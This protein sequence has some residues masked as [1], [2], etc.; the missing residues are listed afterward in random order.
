MAPAENL[1]D[2][3]SIEVVYA[4][5]PRATDVST[6]RLPA[7]ATM[8]DALQASGVLLR[9]ALVVVDGQVQDPG[10]EALAAGVWSKAQSLTHPLRDRDRV[11]LW[12]GLRV[13]PK[14]ARRQRYR[15]HK[16]AAVAKTPSL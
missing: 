4:P 2:D 7:G 6:C 1:S 13:D 11:E 15:R 3:L 8:L 14:E 16:D 9:H 12:R 10:G 5:G